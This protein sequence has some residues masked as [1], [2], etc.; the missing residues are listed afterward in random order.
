MKSRQSLLSN[1]RDLRKMSTDAELLLWRHLRNCQL[2]GVKFKRQ[3]SIE[4]YIIDFV[5]FTPKLVV[6]L[7]GSQ[8]MDSRRYDDNRDACLR[9]NGFTVLRFWNNEVFENLDGVLEVIRL[10]CAGATS[11]SPQPPP[12]RGG[13]VS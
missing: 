2:E 12:A 3:Q 5:A 9:K 13:G 1:A 7:D 6:E 4:E 10:H 11:P 8:H